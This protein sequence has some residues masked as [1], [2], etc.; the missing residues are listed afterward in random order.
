MIP[1]GALMMPLYLIMRNLGIASSYLAV[2]IAHTTMNLPF[3]IWML[4]SFFQEVP[5]ELEQAAQVDG[6]SQI[7]TFFSITV[8][9]AMPG[10]I[11]TGILVMLFSWNEFMFALI[12]SGR[13]SRTL[14]VGIS[15]LI[16]AVT[17]DYGAGAASASLA[18]IPIFFAAVFVQKYLVR[19]LISGAVKG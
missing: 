11:A 4:R 19:G 7:R 14:P 5:I 15:T 12:L 3:S 6:C 16:G 17:V 2:I 9:L 1:A 8:P 10:F 18:C 13:T